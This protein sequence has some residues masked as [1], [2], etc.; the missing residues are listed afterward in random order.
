MTWL[1]LTPNEIYLMKGGT[2][3]QYIDRVTFQ[4]IDNRKLIQKFPTGW[5]QAN[6]KRRDIAPRTIIFSDGTVQEKFTKAQILKKLEL[7]ISEQSYELLK[8]CKSIRQLIETYFEQIVGEFSNS[9]YTY[10]DISGNNTNQDES[11][12]GYKILPEFRF[13]TPNDVDVDRTLDFENI[14]FSDDPITG[15]KPSFSSILLF[16]SW[17]GGLTLRPDVKVD[18]TSKTLEV[19]LRFQPKILETAQE[20]TISVLEK[21]LLSHKLEFPEQILSTAIG[22]L[23]ELWKIDISASNELLDKQVNANSLQGV[24]FSN[25]VDEIMNSLDLDEQVAWDWQGESIKIDTL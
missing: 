17:K 18:R 1:K 14:D 9:F 25:A 11:Y 15:R 16:A 20:P 4:N 6:E 2:A 22:K 13:S 21:S 19:N 5:F 8:N 12:D 7:P 23:G 3:N 10:Q 24:T